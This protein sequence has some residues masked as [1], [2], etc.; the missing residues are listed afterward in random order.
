M[1]E[2]IILVSLLKER[3]QELKVKVNKKLEDMVNSKSF[4]EKCRENLVITKEEQL[5]YIDDEFDKVINKLIARKNMLKKNYQEIC[6]EELG[7]IDA[8]INKLTTH[9]ENMT[10][11]IKELELYSEKLGKFSF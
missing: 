2:L 3:T 5:K 4:S 6:Q 9:I 1:L 10:K 8:E 11:Q 7:I